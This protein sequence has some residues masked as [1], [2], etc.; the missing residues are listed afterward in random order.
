[1]NDFIDV[2]LAFTNY[3][4]NIADVI[5]RYINNESG[6]KKVLVFPLF[7]LILLLEISLFPIALIGAIAKWIITL[8]VYLTDDRAPSLLY[9]MVVIFIEFFALY[10]IV[11]AILML[12]YKLFDFMSN[13]LGKADY[14]VNA[15]D[16][17]RNYEMNEKRK[18]ID[19]INGD[20]EQNKTE[21]GVYIIN[22][23]IK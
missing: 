22:T 15:D 10:Y 21:D 13:G 14:E 6:L 20:L 3:I 8:I 23:D 9:A 5:I 16:F 7:L 4:H 1:M 12:F 11:F 18:E 17:I 2:Q 19:D